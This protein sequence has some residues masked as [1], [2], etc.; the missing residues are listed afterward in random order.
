M[1]VDVRR[2]IRLLLKQISSFFVHFTPSAEA[3]D[4]NE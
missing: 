2:N 1:N 3:L 4:F